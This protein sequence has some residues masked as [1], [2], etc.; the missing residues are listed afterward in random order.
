MR[1][2][3]IPS[4]VKPVRG[5]L[6]AGVVATDTRARLS[7]WRIGLIAAAV[8]GVISAS[9]LAFAAVGTFFICM[10]LLWRANEPVL[11]WCIAFQWLQI[12]GAQWFWLVT[13]DFPGGYHISDMA[14]GLS[15]AGLIALTIGVRLGQG[16]VSAGLAETNA[17]KKV[18]YSI[19]K[20]ALV[21]CV[22]YS[23]GWLTDVKPID[24]SFDAAQIINR[25]LELRVLFLFM[26]L[27]AILRQ[28]R[29]YAYGAVAIAIY[30][31]PTLSSPM[32]AFSALFIIVLL[33]IASEWHPWS[34][35]LQERLKSRRMFRG[36]VV[37]SVT[38]V[39]VAIIWS[40]AIKPIWRARVLSGE[41]T[42]GTSAIALNFAETAATSF[43][44]MQW[45]T[46]LETLSQRLSSG[47]YYFG[48]VI[49]RVPEILPH[50]DGAFTRRA[51]EHVMKPRFLFPDKPIIGSSSWIIR[52][53]AG[54][55]VAGDELRTSV[56][57]TY[58]GEFYIDYGVPGM[59]VALLVYGGIF[60]LF[61]R[62]LRHA[63][64]S[65]D[66]FVAATV[67]L[68]A[69]SFTS[70]EGELIKDFGGV[71]QAFLV[72]WPLFW[73][74]GGYIH[75]ALLPSSPRVRRRVGVPNPAYGRH[76]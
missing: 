19:P 51:L 71:F 60:G 55:N 13:G 32:S 67:V 27:V 21:S 48:L 1:P 12:T 75:D 36:L 57:L 63:C 7:L 46:S 70:Y 68:L 9:P 66:F 73:I 14:V 74:F 35:Y 6:D 17:R 20:L 49:A 64:P 24:L 10:G 39:A 41:M 11:A 30:W 54:I 42:G 62:A 16:R 44:S 18:A 23:V 34:A 47:L 15:L 2:T 52:R 76:R 37:A 50:E 40:G 33:A 26:L 45:T 4:R 59:F 72:Y 69:F 53:Y 28:R 31:I 56:G 29:Q 8:V 43:S 65:H 22:L 25:A 5:R 61:C 38:L 58:M 3:L